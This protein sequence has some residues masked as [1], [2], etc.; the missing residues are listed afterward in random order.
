[1]NIDLSA[2]GFTQE[3]L[4]ERVIETL[5]TSLLSGFG[6][7][8]ETGDLY[9]KGNNLKH[10]LD[11]EIQARVDQRVSEIGAGHVYPAVAAKIETLC[12]QKT[13]E[14]GEPQG[15][16][17]SFTEYLIKRAEQYLSEEVDGDGRTAAECRQRGNSFYKRG[18]RLVTMIDKHLQTSIEAAMK[19]ALAD[20]NSVIIGGI[21]KA[22]KESL[23]SLAANLKFAVQTK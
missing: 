4:Q 18:P 20:A 7:D 5:C 2:I 1:M 21:A 13:S 17:L 11:K 19:T 15:E 3:E 9:T 16:K 23:N 6:Q 22:A 14:W 8:P 12:L 10:A